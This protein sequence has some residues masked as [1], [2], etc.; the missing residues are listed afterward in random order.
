ML[1]TNSAA[2]CWPSEFTLVMMVK[3]ISKPISTIYCNKESKKKPCLFYQPPEFQLTSASS[4]PHTL[5]VA[6]FRMWMRGNLF[7]MCVFHELP[8]QEVNRTYREFFPVICSLQGGS[9]PRVSPPGPD[10]HSRSASPASQRPT[11]HVGYSQEE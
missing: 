2:F 1:K 7:F 9:P 3:E 11:D 5:Q 8:C 6:C 4:L 10:R